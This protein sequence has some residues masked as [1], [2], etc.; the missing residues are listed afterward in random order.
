MKYN[1]N[2]IFHWV[3]FKMPTVFFF[4]LSLFNTQNNRKMIYF[5]CS[6]EWNILATCMYTLTY[7]ESNE[8]Q[9]LAQIALCIRTCPNI[10]A[11]NTS[12]QFPNHEQ[13]IK[14]WQKKNFLWQYIR[15]VQWSICKNAL[16]YFFLIFFFSFIRQSLCC[17]CVLTV[18]HFSFMHMN[19]CVCL[20][21]S[22][23][24]F[25]LFRSLLIYIYIF[26]PIKKLMAYNT[27]L[28]PRS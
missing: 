23:L 7:I 18:I 14:V 8:R 21:S 3:Y 2:P 20:D 10:L 9:V 13:I 27:R 24:V 25:V 1:K 4:I 26:T 11:M 16:F 17:Q 12:V 15:L 28:A 22:W 6:N 19:L 5:H